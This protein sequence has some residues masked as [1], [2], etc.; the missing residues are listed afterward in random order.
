MDEPA[1]R[2]GWSNRKVV[3]VLG[4]FSVV[5]IGLFAG[6]KWKWHLFSIPSG[7]MEPTLLVGDNMVAENGPFSPDEIRRG[8]VVVFQ[9]RDDVNF[10]KRVIGIGGD[11][12]QVI[13]GRVHLNGG[14]VPASD[15]GTYEILDPYDRPL[16]VP[17]IEET[18]D[19]R[20]YGTLDI[21]EGDAGDDTALFIVPDG[22]V[23]VMGDNRDNSS[24]SRFEVG[25]VPVERI[26]GIARTIYWSPKRG[27]AGTYPVR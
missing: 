18:L 19:G 27:G 24:D 12:V 22:H 15:A 26:V 17:L 5:A 23:F 1:D 2:K 4:V 13:G 9:T 14:P 6:F 11:R 16:S 25:F 10:V 3:A 7:A 20:T 8:E 21:R